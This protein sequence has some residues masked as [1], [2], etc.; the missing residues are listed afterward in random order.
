M[1]G[2]IDPSNVPASSAKRPRLVLREDL[3][4]R[5]LQMGDRTLW[6]TKDPIAGDF[7]YFSEREFTVLSA[8][9]G[10]S[11]DAIAADYRRHHGNDVLSPDHLVAFLAQ[12]QRSGLLQRSGASTETAELSAARSRGGFRKGLLSPLAIRLPGVNPDP[13]LDWIEPKTRWIFA[14]LTLGLA[15][16]WMLWAAVLVGLRADTFLLELQQSQAWAS[17]GMMGVVILVIAITKIVHELAHA[18]TCRRYGGSCT[19]IGLMFLVMIPCLYCDVSNAWLQPL[20][21]KRIAIS[22]A[23]ILA[24]LWIAATAAVLWAI[25]VDGPLHWACLS[26]IVV[27]SVSTLLFNGNPLMRYDGYFILSDLLRIPNLA[28]ESSAALLRRIKHLLTGLS[29]AIRNDQTRRSE[30]LLIAYAV[31]SLCYRVMVIGVILFAIH[32]V[33]IAHDLRILAW[34]VT[35]PM[36]FGLLRGGCRQI[37]SLRLSNIERRRMR[38]GRVA[39]G[40]LVLWGG[41]IAGLLFPWPQ[42][43]SLP[44]IAKAVD[45]QDIFVVQPGILLSVV[46]EGTPVDAG[47]VIARLRNRDLDLELESLAAQAAEL[48]Q[49]LDRVMSLRSEDPQ[50][51]AQIPPL[52]DLVAATQ[53]KIAL[54]KRERDA[55]QI[56]A[57]KSGLVFAAASRSIAMDESTDAHL[58]SGT[59]LQPHN[60]GCFLPRG[61]PLCSIGSP[62]GRSVALFASHREIGFVR[63][64][65]SVTLHVPGASGGKVQGEVIQVDAQPVAHLPRELVVNQRVAVEPSVAG[66]DKPLEP[67]YQILVALSD[68]SCLLPLRVTGVAQVHVGAQSLLERLARFLADSIRFELNP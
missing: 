59:L 11:P 47:D 30:G 13:L 51:A 6:V 21:S 41:A 16:M 4:H 61:T 3:I 53:K 10:R 52:R 38:G 49:R 35:A 33:A 39:I 8:L 2:L 9:D 58:W 45:Q 31:A 42:R 23:G 12:T 15:V 64:G 48:V 68:N 14:P 50:F 56:M 25:T 40:N 67:T 18:V 20:R 63:P 24:E 34:L 19:E 44:F 32:K 7:F 43:I 62:N 46:G 27:C 37:G 57:P 54:R 66:G 5:R 1:N 17:A 55:L 22:A 65:Q 26:I 29:P 60:R 28:G 36:L